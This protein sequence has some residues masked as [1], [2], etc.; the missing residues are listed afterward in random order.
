LTWANP[1]CFLLFTFNPKSCVS[2]IIPSHI[3]NQALKG[4]K[5][6]DRVHT[7]VSSC[8]AEL[9]ILTQM[10][11]NLSGKNYV[12]HPIYLMKIL[13]CGGSLRKNLKCCQLNHDRMLPCHLQFYFRMFG[14]NS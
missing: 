6:C 5:E 10:C 13:L 3:R 14:G 1:G 2:H 11:L 4:I 7:A 9:K 8:R 12:F